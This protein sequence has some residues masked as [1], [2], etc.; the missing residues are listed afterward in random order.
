MIANRSLTKKIL[1]KLI[2]LSY[3]EEVFICNANGLVLCAIVPIEE[4][5]ENIN[6]DAPESVTKQEINRIDYKEE[7]ARRVPRKGWRY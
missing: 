3:L 1:S 4:Y 5:R 7:P 6:P 2:E